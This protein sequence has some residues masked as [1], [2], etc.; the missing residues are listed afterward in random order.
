MRSLILFALAFALARLTGTS[1]TCYP[2]GIV[3]TSQMEV[4]NFIIDNPTCTHIGGNVVIDGPVTDLLGLANITE[5]DGGIYI[6]QV[7]L[8][9]FNGLQSLTSVGEAIELEGI[10][11]VT[12]LSSLSNVGS[13]IL[14]DMLAATG[15]ADVINQIVHLGDFIIDVESEATTLDIFHSLESVELFD[16]EN[17]DALISLQ[18]FENVTYIGT[19]IV[20][21]DQSLEQL[22]DFGNLDSIYSI[23]INNAEQLLQV[24][25]FGNATWAHDIK[26]LLNTA[27]VNLDGWQHFTTV[28]DRLQVSHGDNMIDFTGLN[29]ITSVGGNA[30]FGY[31]VNQLSMNG[32]NNLTSVGG[33]FSMNL[34]ENMVSLHGLESLQYVGGDFTL[35]DTYQLTDI[36]ALQY[37]LTIDGYLTVTSNHLLSNC[38]AEAVCSKI[39]VDP[40]N[41]EIAL[42]AAG[43]ET[44]EEVAAACALSSVQGN[45][46]VDFNCNELFENPDVMLAHRTI[47]NQDNFPIAITNAAG[48]FTTY[49]PDNATTSLHILPYVGYTTSDASFTT[50]DVAE[51]F[52]NVNV[53]LCPEGNFHNTAITIS[54]Y[55][56]PVPGMTN[57]YH[58]IVSNYGI[59]DENPVVKFNFSDM[60]GASIVDADGGTI[61]GNTITWNV[62]GLFPFTQVE[63]D[64]VVSV[65]P[66]TL[67]DTPYLPKATVTITPAEIDDTDNEYI[68]PQVVVS[69]YDPNDKTVHRSEVNFLEVQV[70]EAVALDYTIRFQNTGTSA[71]ININIVDTI[72]TDLDL[73]TFEM[74]SASHDYTIEFEDNH[75]TWLFENINLADSLS[76]EPASHGYV[77]FR[78]YTKPNLLITD[79]LENAA[80]IIFDFNEPVITNTAVTTFYQC[81]LNLAIIG[82]S[83]ICEDEDL[84]F[85]SSIAGYD[86]YSWIVD[87]QPYS[88]EES[89][90]ITDPT[91]GNHGIALLTSNA[92]CLFSQIILAQVDTPAAVELV[93]DEAIACNSASIVAVNNGD[94]TWTLDG[95]AF[96]SS[97]GIV[98]TESGLYHVDVTNACGSASAEVNMTIGYGPLTLSIINNSGTLESSQEGTGYQWFL[99]GIAIDGAMS[100]TYVP[101]ETGDYSLQVF[102]DEPCELT[103]DYLHIIIGMDELLQSSFTL[104]PNPAS[105]NGSFIINGNFTEMSSLT[106]YD[107]VGALVQQGNLFQ[108]K[109]EISTAH[110]APGIYQVVIKINGK[111]HVAKLVIS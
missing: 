68:F 52:T 25:S 10:T 70:E 86:H 101:T 28:E 72:E 111:I 97:D 60:P 48:A 47:F 98:A 59:W 77:Q 102:F 78:I 79:T 21:F 87:G 62:S 45:V 95:E 55:S 83:S 38:N 1:Q 94:V 32:L 27:L 20:S 19:F 12:A 105:S 91:P 65:D 49:L 99:D 67:L 69:S 64:V 41:V 16:I 29:N 57:S 110:M 13:F 8:T 36:S 30:Y 61:T 54:A 75:I 35:N 56:M 66:E 71:A 58:V 82:D 73:G 92:E 103:S 100:A 93:Y 7:S 22:P 90:T 53:T 4:D 17:N 44:I 11:D 109:N 108:G 34:F 6:L 23:E 24:P 63:F 39:S 40:L 15:G 3:F 51:A 18:G 5:I 88:T 106:I 96:S 26:V 37:P 81:P 85:S 14:D 84:S 42:N 74:L 89:I 80:S 33:N 43:C 9:N 50:T 76:N 46:F 2:A 31:S 104:S 107:A